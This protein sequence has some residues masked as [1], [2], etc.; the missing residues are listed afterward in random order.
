MH[1]HIVTYISKSEDQIFIFHLFKKWCH[2]TKWGSHPQNTYMASIYM[3]MESMPMAPDVY[4][5]STI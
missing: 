1:V 2:G 4:H 3:T 5:D